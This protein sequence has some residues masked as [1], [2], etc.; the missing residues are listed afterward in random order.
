MR[1]HPFALFLFLLSLSCKRQTLLT[2]YLTSIYIP[3]ICVTFVMLANTAR[4]AFIPL[5]FF[6]SSFCGFV[7]LNIRFRGVSLSLSLSPS[8]DPPHPYFTV[9]NRWLPHSLIFL[10][11]NFQKFFCWKMRYDLFTFSVCLCRYWIFT[12]SVWF[13]VELYWCLELD[14]CV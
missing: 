6:V 11:F 2:Y 8:T 4:F 5:S 1:L 13:V 3:F 10:F 12:F 9:Q 7:W 14:D